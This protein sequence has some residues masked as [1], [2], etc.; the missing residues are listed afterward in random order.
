ML[1]HY[2]ENVG[3]LTGLIDRLIAKSWKSFY[4]WEDKVIAR[5]EDPT[6]LS[7]SQWEKSHRS[8]HNIAVLF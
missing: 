7:D 6:S 4:L 5:R 1:L 3:P 2:K 8:S